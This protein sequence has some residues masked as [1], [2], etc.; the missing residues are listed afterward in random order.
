MIGEPNVPDEPYYRG[1]AAGNHFAPNLWPERPAELRTVLTAYFR[2][3]ERLATE[4]MRVFALA[5]MSLKA[6]S[7]TRS[8]GISAAS[9]CDAIR[10]F[11]AADPA[12]PG[13]PHTDYGSL[14]IL[15]PQENAGGL[16]VGKDGAWV[17]VPDV[18]GC[19]VINIGDLMAR[20]TNDRWV[21]RSIVLWCRTG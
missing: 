19:F 1:K 14:T 3:M 5:S 8:T 10:R 2:E 15:K 6:I 20:W 7:M 17:D 11:A 18:P 12:E 13:G 9:A 16:Q 21:P 4:I